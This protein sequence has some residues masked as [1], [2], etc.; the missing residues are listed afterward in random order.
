M[1]K[2]KKKGKKPRVS[3]MW[4]GVKAAKAYVSEKQMTRDHIDVLQSIEFIL[5]QA[6]RRR[7][8]VDDVVVRDALRAALAG[9]A[10]AEE[11][12]ERGLFETLRAIRH[13]RDDVSDEVWH[14]GLRTVLKSVRRHS[15]LSPGDVS[16]LHFVDGFFP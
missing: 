1:S 2:P 15:T 11:G 8:D 14:G 6:Y 7:Q 5:V 3:K 4:K 13:E 16:Y 9:Q 12:P 10:P